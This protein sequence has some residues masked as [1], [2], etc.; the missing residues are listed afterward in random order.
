[1]RHLGRVVGDEGEL[2]RCARRAASTSSMSERRTTRHGCQGLGPAT[3][4][5]SVTK[6]G[7]A[8]VDS[9]TPVHTIRAPGSQV[10]ARNNKVTVAGAI[11]LRRRLSKIFHREMSGRELRA[12]PEPRVGTHGNNQSR[13][14]Q[15]PRTQRC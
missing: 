2:Q 7:N 8:S 5:T 12:R 6:S 15:S 4:S 11:R 3:A 14:C 1:M 9:A 10:Q 13:I